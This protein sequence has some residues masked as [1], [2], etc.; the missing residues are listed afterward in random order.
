MDLR[1]VHGTAAILPS[2]SVNPLAHIG[3]D[4]TNARLP[5]TAGCF[6]PGPAVITRCEHGLLLLLALLLGDSSVLHDESSLAR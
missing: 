3:D 2:I 1:P 6:L 4:H 5:Q